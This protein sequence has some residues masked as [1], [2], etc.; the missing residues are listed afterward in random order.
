[1]P[2]KVFQCNRLALTVIV[3][4]ITNFVNC[5]VQ[6]NV[7]A[8]LCHSSCGQSP[9]SYGGGRGLILGQVMLDL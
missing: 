3:R 1:V 2:M 9:D 6:L 4:L 7:V 8:R 5:I